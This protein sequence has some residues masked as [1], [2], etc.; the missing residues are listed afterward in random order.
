VREETGAS[1]CVYLD[2]RPVVDVWGGLADEATKRPWSENTRC[3]FFSATKGLAAMAFHLLVDRGQL[4]WET[5]V[6]EVWPGFGKNGKSAIS[7]ETLLSHQAGLAY[8][9]VQLG[10]DDV[11]DPKRA[12]VVREA[13]EAQ[14]PA[15]TP[16]E[17]QGYHALTYGLYAS[18]LFRQVAKE[19]I[20]V[21]LRR[22]L[23]EPLES[24]VFLGT[25]ASEDHAM[26]TLYP[27]KLPERLT[28]MAQKT[29]FRPD[30]AEAGIATSIVQRDS[31]QRKVFLNPKVGGGPAAYGS[32]PVVRRAL[33]W[34]SGT[35]SARGLARMYLPFAGKGDHERTRYL[36]AET[37][38]PLGERLFWSEKDRVI[39]KRLGWT[40]GFLKEER[41]LFSPNP[42]SY[43]HAGM[44]GALGWCDADAGLAWAYVPNKMDWRVRSSRAVRLCRALYECEA[45]LA[46][47]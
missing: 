10:R 13:L 17:D 18:E 37:L 30:S 16:G 35:G 47:T 42:R 33:M 12:D 5:P 31:I 38:A 27:P 1:L 26:A 2:G 19:E 15:W 32:A 45:L 43:G 44:G 34:A 23:I 4:A 28:G 11:L 40:R 25:P 8:L 41:H 14:R 29:F 36:K 7:V 9:D 22:E 46:R 39:R 21:F 24:D 3:V 6:A 20:D